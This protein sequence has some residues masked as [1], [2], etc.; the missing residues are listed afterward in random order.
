MSTGV[1]RRP[2][3]LRSL[4][5][6]GMDPGCPLPP[7][8][9]ASLR[10]LLGLGS[11]SLRCCSVTLGLMGWP[12]GLRCSP[13]PSP[14]RAESRTPG[15]AAKPSRGQ[16]AGSA[17]NAKHESSQRSQTQ[18]WTES[19]FNATEGGGL[20]TG[21]RAWWGLWAMGSPG[22]TSAV[23]TLAGTRIPRRGV[24]M[25]TMGPPSCIS[26]AAGLDLKMC[27][28][29]ERAGQA[30][31]A[32]WGPCTLRTTALPEGGAGS[33]VPACPCLGDYNLMP[34]G[35]PIFPRK[36]KVQILM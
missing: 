16:S 24:R 27:I 3:R 1:T 35:L 6:G 18:R 36:S 25:Q 4:D 17:P 28:S 31:A 26:D 19:A 7:L 8:P 22:S 14:L 11:W 23:L 29:S 33:P 32:V 15:L 5:S 12:G 13:L 20:G 34:A 30:G 10:L 21:S 9:G 2:R